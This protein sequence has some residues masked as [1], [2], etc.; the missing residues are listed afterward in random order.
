M[1]RERTIA[2][3]LTIGLALLLVAS[4]SLAQDSAPQA[5]LDAPERPPSGPNPPQK[6]S[7]LRNA[8]RS[9]TTGHPPQRSF[10]KARLFDSG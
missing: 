2:G 7:I 4:S 9:T 6:G 10:L 8:G 1:R 5:S 3:V